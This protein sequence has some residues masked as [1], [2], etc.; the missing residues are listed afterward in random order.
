M[1][2]RILL[3]EAL[4]EGGW[5]RSVGLAV[6]HGVIAEVRPDAPL[7]YGPRMSGRAIPGM[8]NLH[9]HLFQRAM[10]GLAET[11]GPASD[12]FW[13]WREVMYGFLTRLS[14]EDVEAIAAQAMM[15]MLEGGFTALCEFHYLHHAPDGSAY[16]NPA[17]MA[18]RIAAAADETG[19]GLTLLPVFYAHG[20]FGPVPAAEG[21][22]RFLSS[23]DSYERLLEASACAVQALPDSRLGVA[24]HSLRAATGAEISHLLSLRPKDP[25]HIHVAEQ[26]AEV[27]ACLAWCGARPVQHLLDTQPV[28]GRWCLIHATQMEASETEALSRSGAVAGLC[29]ITE[30]NLG[31]GFFDA[32]HFTGPWGV[33]S[34][35]NV[36]ITAPGELRLLEY[37][38]RLLHRAR[39]VL[40]RGEGSSTGA[41]LYK[42][43]LAGGA[44]ASGRA[45]GRIAPG[46]RADLVWLEPGSEVDDYVFVSGARAIRR[47]MVGGRVVVEE[48][49]HHARDRTAKR[50]RA[51]MERL[52]G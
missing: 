38:Q 37:G 4:L 8:P 33:G 47:V 48:S 21:Q 26:V 14:P 44:Q 2:N 16:A 34:D 45:L 17:E 49:R 1:P 12:S 28:D 27:D 23:L 25:V 5:A 7:N 18:E 43:A 11:R 39:N 40:A 3:D 29:P 52:R 50:F 15:E 42:A 30:A 24:P 20:G 31:D 9:S 36:E 35:S 51:V 19:M 46:A 10:A 41:S 13:T 6:E 22:R 32:T